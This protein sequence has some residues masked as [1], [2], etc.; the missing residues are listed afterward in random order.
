MAWSGRE[1]RQ[2]FGAKMQRDPRPATQEPFAP[3]FRGC[4]Q[5]GPASGTARTN[6]NLVSGVQLEGVVMGM[7]A[8][9]DPD[10][11]CSAHNSDQAW[12][13]DLEYRFGKRY[14]KRDIRARLAHQNIR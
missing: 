11:F 9:I 14:F 4:R 7:I 5:I 2:T 1:L 13:L 12:L 3:D 6:L 10:I 8:A